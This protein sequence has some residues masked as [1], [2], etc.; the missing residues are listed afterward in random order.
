VEGALKPFP[1]GGIWGIS[2]PSPH[3]ATKSM[4]DQRTLAPL[5]VGVTRSR[6]PIQRQRKSRET[7]ELGPGR[8]GDSVSGG[9]R[10]EGV[11]RGSCVGLRG[12]NLGIVEVVGLG[13]P[14][15]V[16]IVNDMSSADFIVSGLRVRGYGSLTSRPTS[17]RPDGSGFVALSK[18]V[19]FSLNQTLLHLMRVPVGL[20]GVGYPLPYISWLCVFW[21]I[22]TSE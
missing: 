5:L 15:R 12:G 11:R 18:P 17:A 4:G 14:L 20:A 7:S 16:C 13:G 8:L 21:G 22:Q 19:G 2:V 1:G 3:R 10:A 6:W 9:A